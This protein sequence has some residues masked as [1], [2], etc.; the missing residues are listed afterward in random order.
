MP[1]KSRHA[2]A[3]LTVRNYPSGHMV[4]L[5]E[6]SRSRMKLDL[7]EFYDAAT[8]RPVAHA[9][10]SERRAIRVSFTQYRRRITRIRY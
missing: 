9:E 3:N 10:P 7:A 4:Y 5:D 6:A 1:L 2:R 8:A